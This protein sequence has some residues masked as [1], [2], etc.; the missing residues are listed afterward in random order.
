MPDDT[1]IR[2]RFE[3]AAARL[4]AGRAEDAARLCR[5]ALGQYPGHPGLLEL[6]GTALGVAGDVGG[7]RE[8]LEQAAGQGRPG[9][10]L[11][12]RLALACRQSGDLTAAERYSRR[13][14]KLNPGSAEGWYGL[15]VTQRRLGDLEGALGSY[16]RCTTMDPGRA[17]AWANLAQ[18]HEELNQLDEARDAATR[19]LRLEAGNVMANLVGAQVETRLDRHEEARER[20]TRLLERDLS[21]NHE[22]LARYHL[23]QALDRLD[24]PAAAFEQFARANRV[25]GRAYHA[26]YGI[27]DGPYALPA[28]RRIADGMDRLAAAAEG[29][30]RA[31]GYPAP[32]FLLGFPRSGTTL[33]DRMLRAH[34][35]IDCLEERETLADLHRDFVLPPDGMERLAALGPDALAAY[36]QAYRRRVDDCAPGRH[37]LLVDKMPLNTLFLPLIGRVF[38]EARIL[39]ALRDPRDVCL[40]CFMQNF[41]LN[42]AMAHF[43]DLE[44]TAEYYCEVMGVGWQALE[45]H[46]LAVHRLRYEDLVADPEGELRR[47]TAFLE[48]PWDPAMLTYREGLAGER[49][50]TPSY[51]QVAQPLYRRAMGRWRR[52]EPQMAPVLERLAPWVAR[53]GYN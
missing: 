30:A 13:A 6:L 52:Y 50:G 46:G 23:G 51:R 7:A 11:L 21:P 44:L 45:L 28:A 41:G 9:P 10:G 47:V 49:I 40:S 18:V 38:P 20:L 42:A 31:D 24:A 34:P 2:K 5:A 22:A 15:A 19:A 29:A 36:R 3:E 25:L 27:D 8:A 33:L 48:L 53:L 26:A 1:P 16:H 12:E 14:L 39:F 32:V 37:G 4:R 35:G 17:D 43:L